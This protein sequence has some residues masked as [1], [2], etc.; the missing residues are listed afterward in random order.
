MKLQILKSN[1]DPE[2][3]L[4]LLSSDLNEENAKRIESLNG[5][6]VESYTIN[7]NDNV[8][9]EETHDIDKIK[10]DQ[11]KSIIIKLR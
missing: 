7:F 11:I 8:T 3:D 10:P 1:K 5:E 2:L 6:I 4:E 9:L